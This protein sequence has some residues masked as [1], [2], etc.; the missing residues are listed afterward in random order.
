[1]CFYCKYLRNNSSLY[2]LTDREGRRTSSQTSRRPVPEDQSGS[3]YLLASPH[4][5]AGS[6]RLSL[7]VFE[8]VELIYL[9]LTVIYALCPPG[10]TEAYRPH[11]TAK[12]AREKTQGATRGGGQEARRGEEGEA[13]GS[14][15]GR[16][17]AGERRSSRSR[18]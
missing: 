12:G 10:D 8:T 3:V 5:G 7:Y 4:R 16:R 2:F 11:R 9:T 13:E 6:S 17:R 14:G 18:S 1:M 15:E